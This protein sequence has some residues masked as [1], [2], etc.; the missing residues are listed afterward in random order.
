MR[1]F[2]EIRHIRSRYWNENLPKMI[3]APNLR[4]TQRNVDFFLRPNYLCDA[5]LISLSTIFMLDERAH[6]ANV[7]P[8]VFAICSKSYTRTEYYYIECY[9][10]IH[11]HKLETKSKNVKSIVS[12]AIFSFKN[13]KKSYELYLQDQ[14]CEI[15]KMF[16]GKWR[17]NCKILWPY[18]RFHCNFF[19]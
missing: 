1:C 15:L 3:R 5:E 2:E 13:R 7:R 6:T 16:R 4:R 10:P 17:I 9:R 12:F 14:Q 19:V 8:N 11:W 18:W